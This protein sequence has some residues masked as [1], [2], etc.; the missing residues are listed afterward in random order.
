MAEPTIDTAGLPANAQAAFTE[1]ARA[2][3]GLAG[4]DLLGLSAFGGW[5]ADDPLY[6][7]TPARSVV[8]FRRFDLGL[9]D[10]L[11]REGIRFGKL[12][13]R[14][15]LIMTPEY[16]AASSDAFPLE[17][18]EIQQLHV[19]VCGA[20][21]FAALQFERGDVRL[22]CEREL[23]SALISLRQ[24]LLAAVGEYK[25]LGELFRD[26]S[27][28]TARVLRGIL[29]LAG[30]EAPRLSA[31]LIGTAVEVAGAK[32]EGLARV[33]GGARQVDLE[34]FRQFYEDLAALAS[35]VDGLARSTERL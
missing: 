32:L 11:A 21:H 30:R 17:L 29:H 6:A 4:E 2:L 9:L 25:R 26:E 8:V 22:Q 13:L 24:G 7:G 12:G 14:A 18:L 35:Y 31:G 3:A 5:L 10:R 20:D 23:K 34:T 33:V 16:I 27:E 19:L 1:L 28:R 15:P